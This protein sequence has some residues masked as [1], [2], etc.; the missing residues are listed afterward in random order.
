MNSLNDAG[1]DRLSLAQ[2]IADFFVWYSPESMTI[3]LPI[4]SLLTH[5]HTHTHWYRPIKMNL[6]ETVHTHS[7]PPRLLVCSR[8]LRSLGK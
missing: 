2:K 8:K 6:S 1:I 5:T 7:F 3:G 4:S